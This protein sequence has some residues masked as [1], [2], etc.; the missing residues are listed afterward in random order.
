MSL[1]IISVY[2]RPSPL[3]W[4]IVI[5]V[6]L[7]SLSISTSAQESYLNDHDWVRLETSH[8]DV[9][10]YQPELESLAKKAALVAERAYAY[11]TALYEDS[12]HHKIHLIITDE[13][14]ITSAH[15]EVLPRHLVHIDHPFGDGYLIER[16]SQDALLDYLIFQEIGRVLD[17]IRIEGF[18]VD[19]EFFLGN[20]VLPSK[21]KPYFY[22]EGF[23]AFRR[24]DSAYINMIAKARALQGTLPT[25]AELSVDHLRAEWPTASL[26][27]MAFGALFVDYLHNIH[28]DDV[29]T[30]LKRNIAAFPL[31]AST[32]GGLQMT[33][34]L[35]LTATYDDFLSEF[36]SELEDESNEILDRPQ[37]RIPLPLSDPYD[38]LGD[39]A[40]SLDGSLIVYQVSAPD[41]AE[42]LRMMR[43]DGEDDRFLLSCACHSVHWMDSSTIVYTKLRRDLNGHERADLFAFHLFDNVEERLTTDE[44]V[45]AAE[46][47]GMG[48]TSFLLLRQ[49]EGGASDLLVFD[50]LSR[51]REI[52]KR[53]PAHTGPLGL[54]VDRNG[55][56]IAVSQFSAQHGFTLTI[57]NRNGIELARYVLPG[58]KLIYPSFSYDGEFLILTSNLNREYEIYAFELERGGFY[59]ITESLTGTIRA[60]PSPDG[61]SI[62]LVR[63]GPNGYQLAKLA[64]DPA[65]WLD[66]EDLI[67]E[68]ELHD[69]EV[70]NRTVLQQ[71]EL[72]VQSYEP[73]KTLLP[74]YRL[75]FL[76]PWN[77]GLYSE[78]HDPVGLISYQMALGIGFAPLEFFYDLSATYSE[79]FPNLVL[80]LNGSPGYHRQHAAFRFPIN[81]SD[82]ESRAVQIGV[83]RSPEQT[84]IY[85]SGDIADVVAYDLLERRSAVTTRAAYAWTIAGIAQ[86]VEIDWLE[87]F[88]FPLLSFKG[89]HSFI[90]EA[91]AAWSNLAEYRLGG[92]LSGDRPLR[93]HSEIERG[94]QRVS[95]NLTY[96]FPLLEIETSCCRQHPLPIFFND[97][98]GGLYVDSGVIGSELNISD[99]K[100]GFGSEVRLKV[101]LGYGV[102]S[103]WLKAGFAYGLPDQTPQLYFGFDPEF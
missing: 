4:L 40:W 45:L 5:L 76:G 62:A 18:M 50:Y 78:N 102:F 42:G 32:V 60:F 43:W 29:L 70:S 13:N 26:Q 20:V 59:Q 84:E 54:A 58:S 30:E 85:A 46:P 44:H 17:E 72:N 38:K 7:I 96:D 37:S 97:V 82:E 6:L 39:V 51:S 89:P 36:Q 10:F 98:R 15:S 55:S 33:T 75:P 66:A 27:S 93:G 22:H 23:S 63:L 69:D 28:G 53:F 90:V 49:S 94:A 1:P 2:L 25:V 12:Q 88:K 83:N 79:I 73:I 11:W 77:I 8:F 100:V 87:S 64:Y 52:L 95:L 80:G 48:S 35:S 103:G 3:L 56:R 61:E 34:G 101:I 41:R 16:N 21:L 24:V 47:M 57:L 19:L 67:S 74:T 86:R 81:Q 71:Q 9:I 91:S 65:N 68:I 14:D 92:G 31:A 99:V